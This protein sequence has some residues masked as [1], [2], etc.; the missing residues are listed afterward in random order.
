MGADQHDLRG[1]GWDDGWQEAFA[2]HEAAGRVPGR[3]CLEQRGSW[4]VL[5]E[6]GERPAS[7]AGRVRHEAVGRPDLPVVGDWVALTVASDDEAARIEAVLPRRSAF[8]RRLA[9]G[10]AEA[11][12]LAANLDVVFLVSGL[13]GDYNPR[14]I[15][16]AVTLAWESGAR[17]VV[18]LNKADLCVDT[19]ARVA[20]VTALA[21]G[22]PVHA[23]RGLEGGGLE[24]FTAE[25]RRGVAGALLGSSG[26]GKST[27][28]NRLLGREALATA[29]VREHDARGRHTTTHR[30]LFV[31]P[32]GGLLVDTPGLREFGLWGEGTGLGATFA[33]IDALAPGCRYRDCRHADEPGCAVRQA[34]ADGRLDA[35]RL[36]SYHKLAK[37]LAFLNRQVDQR[38]A[39]EEKRRWKSIH[40]L[41]KK[42][43]PRA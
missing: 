35:E 24:V 38:A 29:P 28:I 27:I 22:V 5:T 17:P 9:G 18:V 43:K 15:E 42:F 6:D 26:V 34:V 39:L 21:P 1:F 4:R 19:E 11:Q 40:K 20:E 37:E 16:R 2:E 10:T 7:L 3:V 12:V 32:S 36:A 14:R 8:V 25:L 30:Q 31:L 41:A 13:D 23:T 33:D